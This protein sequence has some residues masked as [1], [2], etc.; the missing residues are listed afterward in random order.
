MKSNVRQ[1]RKL[2]KDRKLK[3]IGSMKYSIIKG[4]DGRLT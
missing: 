4:S 1:S 3:H 2:R